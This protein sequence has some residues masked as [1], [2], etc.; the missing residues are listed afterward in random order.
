MR[1]RNAREVL[2]PDLLR[3][4][5]KY[6]CGELLYIPQKE[7]F[8]ASW[9][10]LNGTKAH[11]TTRNGYIV[12]KYREGSSVDKL[13]EEFCLSESSIR[14]ITYSHDCAEENVSV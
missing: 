9:G 12:K 14:K 3:E 5:Q 4:I 8:R 10:A 1:Y 2:P 11:M 13:I 7:E 6:T